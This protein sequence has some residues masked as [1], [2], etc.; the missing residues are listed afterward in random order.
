MPDRLSPPRP[1]DPWAPLE[2]GLTKAPA[3]RPR[4]LLEAVSGAARARHFSRR[5]EEAYVAWIRRFILFHGKRHPLT[6]GSE[7]INAFLTDLAVAR[8]VSAS[9]QNQALA[10][11]LFLYREVLRHDI[12]PLSGIVRARRPRRLPVVLT[13]D[14]VGAV[15]AQLGDPPRLI[16]SLLYGAGLRL[17]EC[18]RLRVKDLDFAYN[19]IHVRDGKGLKERI[20]MLPKSLREPLALHLNHGDKLHR[21]DRQAGFG[22]VY[23]PFALTTRCS[24]RLTWVH[25]CSVAG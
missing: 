10:A 15:L 4:R 18:L 7:E 11:I 2:P 12:G 13:R 5:T 22:C 23:L 19:Q 20:T 14:E 6:L 24:G 1:P 9:T 3:Q 8:Q 25:W 21:A 17:L 16:A